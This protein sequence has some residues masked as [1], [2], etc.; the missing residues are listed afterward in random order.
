MTAPTRFAARFDPARI[1]DL[2]RR[3]SETIWPQELN[4]GEADA[5][6]YGVPQAYLRDLLAYWAE[7]FDWDAAERFFNRFDQYTIDIDGLTTHFVHVRSPHPEA[8]PLL[9]MHGWPGSVFEFWEAIPRLTDPVAHGGD[10]ADAFHV[11]CP[12]LPG[13]GYSEPARHRGMGPRAIAARHDALMQALG[14]ARYVVQGGDWGALVARFMPEVCPDSL[15]GVHYNLVM[16]TPPAGVDDSE[17]LLTEAE[18]AAL[19]QARAR[20]FSVS[21][22]SHEQGTRPQTLAYA[23]SDSPAGLAA[24]IAEKFFAWTDDAA[25][26]LDG[27]GRDWLLCNISLYWMTRSIG[28]SIRLYR[29]YFDAVFAGQGPQVPCPPVPTGI[30]DYPAEIWRSPRSW[31]TREYHL[32]H[33]N[34]APRGGHFAALEVPDVF[35][36]ELQAFGR[37]LRDITTN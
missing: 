3:L 15:I 26:F 33:W 14:Y 11:V 19:E 24:W 25:P 8:R 20:D 13:Y 18:R 31:A 9:M 30:T 4:H 27:P 29:E 16:P 34:A 21:G 22:Y 12:S 6:D 5:W 7:G 35:A 28:S 17:N 1:A 23:L 36:Q 32:V 37:T 2:R 10:A